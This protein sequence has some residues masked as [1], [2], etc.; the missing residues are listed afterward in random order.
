MQLSNNKMSVVARLG[1]HLQ[2]VTDFQDVHA[3]GQT[4]VL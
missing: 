3:M 4:K 1:K 2:L